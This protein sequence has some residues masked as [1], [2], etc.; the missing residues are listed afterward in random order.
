MRCTLSRKGRPQGRPFYFGEVEFVSAD[1]ADGISKRKE[2]QPRGSSHMIK[3]THYHPKKL[4]DHPSAAVPF[5][6]S[7]P[8]R[9]SSRQRTRAVSSRLG[10]AAHPAAYQFPPELRCCN[11]RD[12][13]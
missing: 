11:L 7:S 4:V 8:V 13:S 10:L 5:A 9:R 6:Q 12:H 3:L 2:N 1:F